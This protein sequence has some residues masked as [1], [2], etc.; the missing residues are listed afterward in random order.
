MILLLL[1]WFEQ[2][3]GWKHARYHQILDEH[4]HQHE[5]S[6]LRIELDSDNNIYTE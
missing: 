6:A 1:L 4:Q 3:N 5:H 2:N